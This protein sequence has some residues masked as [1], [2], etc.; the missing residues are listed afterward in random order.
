MSWNVHQ[1]KAG[2]GRAGHYIQFDVMAGGR[3]VCTLRYPFCPLFKV[4]MEE[5]MDYALQKR[6]TLK[7]QKNVELWID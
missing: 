4:R 7:Y 6:P 2:M 1:N 3:F 5:L